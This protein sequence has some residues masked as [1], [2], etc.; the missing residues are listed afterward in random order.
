MVMAC[1]RTEAG[2][3]A[4][5]SFAGLSGTHEVMRLDLADLQDRGFARGRVA[6]GRGARPSSWWGSF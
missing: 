5:R 1:R 3:E 2:E 4:A 6:V